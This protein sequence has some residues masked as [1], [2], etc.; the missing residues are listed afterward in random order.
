MKYRKQKVILYYSILFVVVLFINGY[1]LKL[2]QNELLVRKICS[3]EI[4]YDNFRNLQLNEKILE[5][6]ERKA[7]AFLKKYPKLKQVTCMD[8]IGYLTYCMMISS[9]QLG[10]KYV[11]DDGTFVRVVSRLSG[12]PRFLEIYGYYKAILNDLEYFPVPMVADE[13]ADVS[14]RDSWFQ[15]RTYGGNRKHEG[16]DLMASNNKRGF[17]PVVSMTD[18]IVEK[19]GWLEQ[20]GY[21]IGIRSASGGYFYYAH[22]DSYAPE[23]E[24]G[25]SVIA[26]Q[27][28]GFM[29][30]SGYGKE[31]TTGKFD[32]HLHLGIYVN[33]SQGEM[34]VDPYC[35]LKI[36]KKKRTKWQNTNT[37][38]FPAS[39]VLSNK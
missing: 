5:K 33:T 16:C 38:V 21:R 9:Y 26:G 23:L 6:A 25:N 28:L 36:L 2:L 17:F 24:Q 13:T 18:G 14:F 10:G 22:L 35:V 4:D 29:G 1:V 11:A 32:V 3:Q 37:S 12:T 30:D 20:G 34:S 7:E 31:G 27:L 15:P 39:A 19:M 8:E